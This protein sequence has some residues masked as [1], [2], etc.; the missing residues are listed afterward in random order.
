MGRK[1][2]VTVSFP[3][4]AKSVCRSRKYSYGIS[5]NEV[6]RL[7]FLDGIGLARVGSTMIRAHLGAKCEWCSGMS[8]HIGNTSLFIIVF[9]PVPMA[10]QWNFIHR[11]AQL[12]VE[13]L[14]SACLHFSSS[15]CDTLFWSLEEVWSFV[16]RFVQ[17][18]E[19]LARS[20]QV[21]FCFSFS[22]RACS[23]YVSLKR[24]RLRE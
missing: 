17:L 9:V 16:G 19:V 4:G 3:I 1:A 20:A 24:T 11:L 7:S 13:H 12:E 5:S 6:I 14:V 18:S 15:P 23:G 2:R 10:Y 8:S 22:L 21:L